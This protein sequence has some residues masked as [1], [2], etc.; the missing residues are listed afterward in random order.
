MSILY[1]PSKDNVVADTRL[2]MGSTAH[3]EEGRKEIAKELH[4]LAHLEV[5]L[6]DS[7]KGRF[8]L[9]NECESS[10]V[11]EVKDKWMISKKESWKK[12]IVTGFIAKFLNCQQ[13]KVEHQRACGMA[14]NIALPQWKWE[15]INMDFIT[16]LS[17]SHRKH[18]S[19]WVIVD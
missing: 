10:L 7:S 11:V 16:R 15:M 9:M 17:R 6:V 4:R 13:V 18:A 3:V 19:I 2:S 12:L 8:V 14:Q 1:H 5:C